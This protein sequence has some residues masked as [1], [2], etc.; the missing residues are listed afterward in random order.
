MQKKIEY[1]SIENKSLL[2]SKNSNNYFNP[3]QNQIYKFNDDINDNKNDK[4]HQYLKNK[5][6]TEYKFIPSERIDP[7]EAINKGKRI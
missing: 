2:N 1:N 7:E 5:N 3:N 6:K 4:I